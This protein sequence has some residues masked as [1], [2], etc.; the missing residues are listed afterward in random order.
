LNRSA[1]IEDKAEKTE[2][3]SSMS[4]AAHKREFSVSAI[5]PTYCRPKD[6]NDL[7]RSLFH[8]STKPLEIIVVDDTPDGTIRDLCREHEAEFEEANI[9]LVYAKNP[10]G[11]SLAA[12][13]NVGFR[14]AKGELISFFDSDTLLSPNYMEKIV[15]VFADYPGALGVQGWISRSDRSRPSR[16]GQLFNRFFFLEHWAI[17]SCRFFEYPVALTG[18]INCERLSGSNMTYKRRV[19]S[20]FE[21]DESLKKYSYMED[22]LFS[23]SIFKRYPK[24]LFISPYARCIHKTSKAGRVENEEL[25]KQKRQYSKY[26]LVKLFGTKGVF[27]YLWQNLGAAIKQY[28][29]A[30][31][32]GD[33]F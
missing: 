6:L 27:L 2:S 24:G 28:L 25:K 23:H 32:F 18:I 20:E 13:R 31:R 5:I 15:E 29:K 21:F 12:S 9:K 17:D 33:Q 14:L 4:I 11:R 26:V 10:G 1:E 16:L 22:V 19:F 3:R 7:F 30:L 8:Q